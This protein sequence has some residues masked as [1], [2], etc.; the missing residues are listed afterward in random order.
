MKLY[1]GTSS[2]NL[3]SILKYGIKRSY[4]EG[5]DE[6]LVSSLD[7]F[8]KAKSVAA[9]FGEDGIV[10]EFDVSD[11]HVIFH[12]DY[13]HGEEFD[14]IVVNIDIPKSSITNII[15]TPFT[16]GN[17]GLKPRPNDMPLRK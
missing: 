14:T 6:A 3:N 8:K 16:F 10:I 17:S 15:K 5:Y 1:H 12:P 4:H 7:S 9:G 2:K 11:E 13:G